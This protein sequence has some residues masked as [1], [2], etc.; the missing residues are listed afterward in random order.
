MLTPFGK[1]LRQLRVD[2]GLKLLDVADA[3]GVSSAYVSAIETGRKAVPDGLVTD[4]RRG[5]NLN[6]AERNALRRAADQT[7]KEVSVDSLHADQRELVAAFARKLDDLPD[8]LLESIRTKVLKSLSSEHPFARKRRGMVVAPMSIDAI[9]NFSE[10]VRAAFTKKKEIKF[11]IIEVLEFKLEKLIP[12]FYLDVREEDELGDVEGLVVSGQNTLCLR[13]DVYDQACADH[14]RARFTACHELG[15]FLMHRSVALARLRDDDVPI[16][17]DSE[18]QADT[19]AGAL[20][21]SS[22]HCHLFQNADEAASSCGMSKAAAQHQLK[23][24]RSKPRK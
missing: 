13:R 16:Y 18:W 4:L 17:C 14:G 21:M 19:F 3:L 11:P 10:K 7:R 12:D 2:K 1:A 15:H 24:Y 22:K 23:L 8:E 9:R 6:E 20:M 5:L